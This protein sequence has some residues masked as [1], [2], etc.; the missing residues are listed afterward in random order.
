MPITGYSTDLPGDVGLDA[1]VLYIGT[2]LWGASRGGLRFSP[3]KELRQLE[4]DGKR[5]PERTMDRIIGFRPVISGT[6][7]EIDTADVD[8]YEPANVPSTAGTPGTNE[9][10]TYTPYPAGA[11]FADAADLVDVRLIFM[12]G[13]GKYVA[14]YFPF[15]RVVS[16]EIVGA[17]KDE[18]TVSIEI[19][20]RLGAGQN[21]WDA[22][23]KIEIRDALP[24]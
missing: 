19:E 9:V 8:R 23:Y 7:L 13:D 10:K 12:R 4:Y 5:S 21:R 6:M 20:A 3:N 17:D 1:G 15:A 22:P 2:T 16:Y 14:V 18:V 11:F 24:T